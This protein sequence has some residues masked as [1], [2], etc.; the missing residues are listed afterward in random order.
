MEN[1][2]FLRETEFKSANREIGVFDLV[3]A[4]QFPGS[5]LWP[6]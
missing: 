2:E 6:L 4:E 1:G 3:L 5:S